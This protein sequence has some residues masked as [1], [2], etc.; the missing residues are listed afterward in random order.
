MGCCSG[1]NFAPAPDAALDPNQRVNFT[2]G[3][4]LGVDDFRQEH[5]YLAARDE[6]ALRETIGYGAISGLDVTVRIEGTQIEVR[7]ASG[8]A[9]LPDGKLVAVA[10]DQC[11]RLDEWL[12]GP[13]KPAAGKSGSASVYVVLRHAEVSGTPVPIP[14]EPCRDE[15]A[16]QAD[17]RIADSFAL[18]FSWQPPT[19]LEDDGSRTFAAWLRAIEVHDAPVAAVDI[20]AF[21]TAVEEGVKAATG[22]WPRSPDNPPLAATPGV[23]PATDWGSPPAH[24]VIPRARYAEYIN[25][26]FDVWVRK[27]RAVYAAKH[28]PAPPA[29]TTAETGLLLAAIDFTLDTTGNLVD[30]KTSPPALPATVRWLGRP[31]LLHLR[32]LQEWLLTNVE[33]DAPREAHYVLGKRD[34]RLPNAQD[35]ASDFEEHDG[36]LARVDLMVDSPPGG[37]TKAVLRP[38]VKWPGGAPEA[39]GPDY[40]GPNMTAPIPVSDGGTG[41]SQPPTEQGQLLVGSPAAEGSP[42]TP[43]NFRLGRL[44]GQEASPPTGGNITV[45]ADSDAPN[46]LL[47]TVQDIHAG[48]SPTFA[49][50]TISGD[51]D[52]GDLLH[53]GRLQLDQPLGIAFGGTG[54]NQHPQRLQVLVGGQDGRDG[55][56]VLARLVNGNNTT[57][58]LVPPD[59]ASPSGPEDSG[60]WRIILDATSSGGQ[61]VTR[62]DPPSLTIEQIAEETVIDTVQPLH[63]RATP[64]FAG[65]TL[66]RLPRLANSRP[67][68]AGPG[69]RLGLLERGPLAWGARVIQTQSEADAGVRDDDQVLIFVGDSEEPIR[70]KLPP[71]FPAL[72]QQTGP[73]DSK[74]VDSRVLVIKAARRGGVRVTGEIENQEQIP[75]ESS[76]SLTVIAVAELRRWLIIGRS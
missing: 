61:I 3:M 25:A 57:V 34:E 44:L 68:V 18:D 36:A 51:A 72:E 4:V 39:G 16:L 29:E 53:T 67:V 74:A 46:I 21:Q 47:D 69:G 33:N 32:M 43:A 70:F 54:L 13:G 6:R 58:S 28:G 40:Y 1:Y 55:D 24:L 17:S 30:P 8:L 66:T 31:Q 35:L 75:L 63:R 60:E 2:F 26:A 45:D 19:S 10:A 11:A 50:L 49:G 59:F 52:V 7:V 15:S 65:A 14:G 56:Y 42:P 22:N 20:P 9:L 62:A 48:A 41:Q 23:T 12:A 27:L 37:D 76:Q 64:T 71:P 38:A 5:A 73:E